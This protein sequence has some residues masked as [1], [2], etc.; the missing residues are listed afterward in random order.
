LECLKGPLSGFPIS[1][2]IY[3]HTAYISREEEKLE[4]K[5]GNTK[6]PWKEGW[7]GPSTKADFGRGSK[8]HRP[9]NSSNLIGQKF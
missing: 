1:P 4:V 9:M 5:A 3:N 8:I 2:Q 6:I 7:K